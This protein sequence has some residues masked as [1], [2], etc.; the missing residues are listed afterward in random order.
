MTENFEKF[1]NKNIRGRGKHIL[2]VCEEYLD[3]YRDLLEII[4]DGPSTMVGESAEKWEKARKKFLMEIDACETLKKK[5][6]NEYPLFWDLVTPP[7]E[8]RDEYL[9]LR[10]V[11]T[12]KELEWLHLGSRDKIEQGYV[13]TEVFC[14]RGVTAGPFSGWTEHKKVLRTKI[15]EL[16]EV[17]LEFAKT[18]GYEVQE[19]DFDNVKVP[20]WELISEE[21]VGHGYFD[22]EDNYDSAEDVY[23]GHY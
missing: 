3:L 14:T 2:E 6:L 15:V 8:D 5:I 17:D 18:S 23:N 11:P 1:I 22:Q 21:Q 12:D 20:Q 13:Y 19:K 16:P 4:S 7:G 9:V 10:Y